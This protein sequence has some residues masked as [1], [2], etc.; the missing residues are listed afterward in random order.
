MVE[1][2]KSAA[3]APNHENIAAIIALCKQSARSSTLPDEAYDYMAKLIDE[4]APRNAAELFNL[5]GDFMTDGM[6][7]SEDAAFK[8]CEVM[9]KVLLERKLVIVNQR[10]TIV[11]EKLSNPVVLNQM[12]Q[13]GNVVRD[14]DFLDP[15][16]GVDR[17]R[18]MQNSTFEA[19]KLA[20]QTEK[21]R[22]KA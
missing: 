3:N 2:V 6:I 17:S 22:Q 18:P 19:G 7:F 14:E 1:E 15:F 12:Q 5:I 21:A 20:D 10:D 13:R 16:T 4:D 9:S 11:A 8:V